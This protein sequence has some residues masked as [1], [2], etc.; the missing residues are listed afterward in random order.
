MQIESSADQRSIGGNKCKEKRL[1]VGHAQRRRDRRLRIADRHRLAGGHKGALLSAYSVATAGFVRTFGLW[2]GRATTIALNRC[3][4]RAGSA[5]SGSARKIRCAAHQQDENQHHGTEMANIQHDSHTVRSDIPQVKESWTSATPLPYSVAILLILYRQ[6]Y[7]AL[8]D[9][10][11]SH[12]LSTLDFDNRIASQC[13]VTA[14]YPIAMSLER[15]SIDC[16]SR[17]HRE[18]WNN[19]SN[20]QRR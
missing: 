19:I 8:S 16:L 18:A 10:R 13:N 7:M 2:T 1:H 11:L 12:N 3:A 9:C 4:F 15:S 14:A 6:T 5:Y 20:P 17:N